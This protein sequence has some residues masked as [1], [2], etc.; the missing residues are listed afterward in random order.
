MINQW[1]RFIILINILSL[2][3]TAVQKRSFGHAVLPLPLPPPPHP[4]SPLHPAWRLYGSPLQIS[5]DRSAQGLCPRA[6]MCVHIFREH[7]FGRLKDQF[8][9][10]VVG[11]AGKEMVKVSFL[12]T[13]HQ[14]C[15]VR[16]FKRLGGFEAKRLQPQSKGF[17]HV[18]VFQ[19]IT[20]I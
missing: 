17:T 13:T 19:M 20:H 18:P 7:S 6:A 12:L 2:K 3:R 8:G 14:E 9:L 16:A 10:S 11:L 5:G 15:V 4:C 1:A